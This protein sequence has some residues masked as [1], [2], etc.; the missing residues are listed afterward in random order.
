MIIVLE[1]GKLSKSPLG[2]LCLDSLDNILSF[3]WSNVKERLAATVADALWIWNPE[4][5][6]FSHS[7]YWGIPT[8]NILLEGDMKWS[9][10][11]KWLVRYCLL[12]V[13]RKTRPQSNQPT[14]V[15]SLVFFNEQDNK[16]L[17][18]TV[19][20]NS[21]AA[22]EWMDSENILAVNLVDSD[23]Q[24]DVTYLDPENLPADYC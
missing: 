9:T 17:E 13:R 24:Y 6:R 10:N 19:H 11:D 12:S 4:Q 8:K 3:W 14:G 18:N 5:K 7:G 1:N 22:V 15:W 16:I 23:G 21:V 20:L 2:I